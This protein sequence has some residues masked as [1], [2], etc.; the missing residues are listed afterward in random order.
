MEQ[1]ARD[2]LCV[3]GCSS[4]SRR[5]RVRSQEEKVDDALIRSS[6]Q[7]SHG[8]RKEQP[9]HRR[10]DSSLPAVA[11]ALLQ[12][13]RDIS[14][15]GRHYPEHRDQ[16][17]KCSSCSHSPETLQSRSLE[18]CRDCTCSRAWCSCWLDA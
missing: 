6:G 11:F 5:P 18:S 9:S 17:K 16:I 2:M 7:Q 10:L 14:K 15:V 12:F 8:P 1:Q 3:K 4:S 13:F